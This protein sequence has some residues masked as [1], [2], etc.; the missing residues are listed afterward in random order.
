MILVGGLCI[1]LPCKNNF[2]FEHWTYLSAYTIFEGENV[3]FLLRSYL[4]GG[5]WAEN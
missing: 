3:G 4:F 1:W 5:K 2:K